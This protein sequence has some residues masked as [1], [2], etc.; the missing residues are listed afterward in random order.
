MEE[1]WETS[2]SSETLS[3]AVH[4]DHLVASK[5]PDVQAT[6]DKLSQNVWGGAKSS[7][8]LRPLLYTDNN[9]LESNSVSILNYSQQ[10]SK[11]KP[12]CRYSVVHSY[13]VCISQKLFL[14]EKHNQA[15]QVEF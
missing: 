2:T 9:Q 5:N 3:L 1:D 11:F 10:N 6:L 8:R 14:K 7:V 12:A 4:W 15:G 13:S